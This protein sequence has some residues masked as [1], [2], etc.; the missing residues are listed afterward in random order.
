M[1]VGQRF[2]ITEYNTRTI[3]SGNATAVE[4]WKISDRNIEY[5]YLFDRYC[6][7]LNKDF[8]MKFVILE[9]DEGLFND[10][11]INDLITV[12]FTFKRLWNK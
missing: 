2:T 3:T 8:K 12:K 10:D 7:Q 11:F 5:Q 6:H 9:A 1:E 4:V